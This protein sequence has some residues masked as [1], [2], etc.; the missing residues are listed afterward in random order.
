MD[1]PT[2]GSD[3][4]DIRVRRR[5]DNLYKRKSNIFEV[6]YRKTNDFLIQ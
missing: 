5:K 6:V 1:E 2:V 4:I 3:K